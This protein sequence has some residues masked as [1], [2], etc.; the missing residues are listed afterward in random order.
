M[1][2]VKDFSEKMGK[3]K[4]N[5][6]FASHVLGE[7]IEFERSMYRV[8]NTFRKTLLKLNPEP[9]SLV[10]RNEVSDFF[11]SICIGPSG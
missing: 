1:D 3:E 11:C 8:Y 2:K 5:N 10:P 7:I 4:R 9:L 6:T